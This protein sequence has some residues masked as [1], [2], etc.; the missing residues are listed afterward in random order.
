M[1]K[2]DVGNLRKRGIRRLS[3][4]FFLLFSVVIEIVVAPG[5]RFV[6]RVQHVIGILAQGI[7]NPVAEAFPVTHAEE[8][9]L[10]R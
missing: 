3:L 6:N 9:L 7:K 8:C 4:R 2:E 10:S 1:I 5:S